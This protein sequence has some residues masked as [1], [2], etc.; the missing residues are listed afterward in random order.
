MLSQV[1][2]TL[3]RP[4]RLLRSISHLTTLNIHLS[5]PVTHAATS[6]ST[7]LFY[8]VIAIYSCA[9]KS[10]MSRGQTQKLIN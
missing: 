9:I 5:L 7:G 1:P 6:Y 4:V 10:I 8:P 2:V 3:A